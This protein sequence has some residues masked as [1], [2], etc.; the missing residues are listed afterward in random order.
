MPWY[1]YSNFGGGLARPWVEAILWNGSR[2]VRLT[3]LVD[4][5]ADSSVLDVSVAL[6]LGL[7]RAQA[8]TRTGI[9][10]GGTTVTHL[11]WPNA[12]LHLQFGQDKFLFDGSFV[13][14]PT[15][16]NPLNVL[17]RRDFF[18]R[19]VVQF[20]DAAQMFNIDLSPHFPRPSI[21]P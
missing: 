19:Y 8:Q 7:M 17:G 2:F 21:K 11:Y 18:Q 16:T 1:Q 14:T 12:P 4:S 20:W 3:A 9:A 13:E 5:G 10:T 15:G 6:R